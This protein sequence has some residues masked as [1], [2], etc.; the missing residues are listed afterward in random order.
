MWLPDSWCKKFSINRNQSSRPADIEIDAIILHYTTAAHYMTTARWFAN[1]KCRN[2][3]AHFVVGRNGQVVQLV[4]VSAKA[5][6][7]GDGE[8]SYGGE[9]KVDPN[10]SSIGI[11]IANH[12]LLEQKT[13]GSFATD[14]GMAYNR[15]LYPEPEEAILQY[16]SGLKVG[17]FWEPYPAMQ[18]GAVRVLVQALV[19]RYDIPANRIV[20]HQDT[21]LPI[22][23][24]KDPGPLWPWTTFLGSICGP[25][26]DGNNYRRTRP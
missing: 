17:G 8:M 16:D 12:G 25:S 6:H 14:W 15:D 11:E 23:L 24:K 10:R 20:G 18:V 1:P 13:D 19:D 5:W 4:P 21:A 26:G 2:A 22:G 9:M 7:A 3:S